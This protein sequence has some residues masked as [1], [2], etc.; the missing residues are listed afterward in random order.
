MCRHLAYLG[1]QAIPALVLTD[2]PYGRLR[3]SGRPPQRPG[4]VNADG[5]AAGLVLSDGTRCLPVTGRA[6]PVWSDASLLRPAR[7]TRPALLA[8]GPLL[9]R[10]ASAQRAGLRP[11]RV[12]PGAGQP[13]AGS[14][15]GAW[16]TGRRPPPCPPRPL[17]LEARTRLGPGLVRS[18]SAGWRARREPADAL[19]GTFIDLDAAGINRPFQLPADRRDDDRRALAAATAVLPLGAPRPCRG[20]LRT[21]LMT[22]GLATRAVPHGADPRGPA[23]VDTEPAQ[24]PWVTPQ[25]PATCSPALRVPAPSRHFTR[26]LR[27][28]CT[29]RSAPHTPPTTGTLP[30]TSR[31]DSEHEP[32][33]V[34]KVPPGRFPGRRT[35]RGPQ[36]W[37][38]AMPKTLP[39]KW[40]LDERAVSFSRNDHLAARSSLPDPGPSDPHPV[41]SRP[42]SRRRPAQRPVRAW[43]LSSEKPGFAHS[44]AEAVSCALVRCT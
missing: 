39:P 29:R 37:P 24:P 11:V 13:T 10:T 15:A 36:L 9:P 18:C 34:D 22:S 43:L 12:G 19:A 16:A 28:L 35:A 8:R 25:R 2:P 4:T 17:A 32:L 5:F 1:P 7:V 33:H 23:W 6:M 21:P 26:A 3:Q 14:I 42:I 27:T 30:K 38:H 40:V 31:E 44:L 20:G 41:A